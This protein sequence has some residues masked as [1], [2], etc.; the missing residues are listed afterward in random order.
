MCI[1]RDSDLLDRGKT[2][3]VESVLVDAKMK[4]TFLYQVANLDHNPSRRPSV[5]S[6]FRK[7]D[8]QTVA[9]TEPDTASLPSFDPGTS[10]LRYLSDP[11]ESYR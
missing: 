1:N 3:D 5:A 2:L 8:R 6:M 9:L 7:V 11:A 10:N 4:V